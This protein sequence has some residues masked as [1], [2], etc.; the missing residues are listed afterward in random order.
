MKNGKKVVT[1]SSE[2]VINLFSWDWFGDCRDRITGHPNSIE[3]MV[4]IK[5]IYKLKIK[6][7]ENTLI[8]GNEDGF[9]RGVSVYPNS[10]T[11]IL[12]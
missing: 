7:D 2:G 11:D 6:L 9:V 5:F 1:S 10:I 8:T 3:S 12:G 4:Y